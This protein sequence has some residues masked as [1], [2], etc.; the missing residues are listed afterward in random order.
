M[1]SKRVLNIVT[2]LVL[3]VSVLPVA[4]TADPPEPATEP[5][6]STGA[7]PAAPAKPA[8]PEDSGVESLSGSFVAFDPSVG[9]DMC[10]VPG[11]T[12]TFCF[13][14]HSYTTDWEYVYNLWT[15][16]PTDWT[17][18]DVYVQGT[19]VCSSGAS[20]GAFSWSFQT[21]P[22]EVNIAHSRNQATTDDCVAYYCFEV[23]SGAGGGD[24]LESWYWDGDGYGSPPHWPCSDDQ[25]TPAGQSA[26]DEYVNPQAA[27][28]ECLPGLFLSPDEINVEGC[29]ALP[30]THIFNLLNFTGAEGTFDLTYDVL[31]G[32]ATL[33]GPDQIYLGNGVN[34]DFE[35]ELTPDAC[36]PEGAQVI[37]TIEADGNG[38][39]DLSTITKTILGEIV[40]WESV[41]NSAPAWAG[42]GYPV[43]GCTAMN[44]AGEWVTY[45]IGDQSGY[46]GFWGYNHNTNTWYQPAG[47]APADR[48]AP[49]WAY[50]DAT[51][52]CYMTGGATAAGGGNLAE[53]WQYD[54]V[55]DA[56]TQLPNFTSIRDFHD[57]WV[58]TLNG[59]KFLCIGGGVN[60]S[61]VLVQST[62]CYDIAGGAWNAEN[63]DMDPYPTDPFGA[64]DGTLHADTGDQFWYVGGA[65][66]NFATVTDAAWYWDDADDAWHQAGN[67]GFPRYRVEGDF[68]HG[69]FYQLAGS[70]GGFTPT[71]TSVRGVNEGGTWNWYQ[72]DD[73]PVSRMDNVA[74]MLPPYTLAGQGPVPASERNLEFV[75]PGPLPVGAIELGLDWVSGQPAAE[76][77]VVPV[78]ANPEAVLWDQYANWSSTDHAAQDFETAYDIY[79]IFA[80]DDFENLETWNIDTI[81]TR[82]G[83]G[84][85]VDLNNATAINWWICPDNGGEPLCDPPG[86]GNE[87]WTISL[88]PTDPQVALGVSEPEDVVLTLDTPIVL[89]AGTWWLVYQVALEN[90]LYGQYGWSSTTDAVWGHV[91]MQN[92]P[93]GGFGMGTGWWDNTYAYDFMFRLEGAIGGPP[94]ETMWSVDGYGDSAADYV[95]WLVQCP[96]CT[97]IGWLDGY[98][99]DSETGDVDPTC[100]DAVV[101]IEPGNLDF[102]VDPLTGY[103]GPVELISGT[104]TVDATAPGY[105]LET[106]VVD[107]IDQMTTTVDFNLWRP[108]ISVEPTDFVSVPVLIDVPT[109]FPMVI[110]NVGHLPLDFEISEIPGGMVTLDRAGPDMRTTWLEGDVEIGPQVLAEL[111]AGGAT[112]FFV[113]MRLQA[114]LSEASAIEDWNAR[115]QYVYDSLVAVTHAQNAVISYAQ[116]HGLEYETRLVINAVFIKGGTLDDV[117]ALAALADV[118]QISANKIREL[119]DARAEGIDA[120]G[121]NMDN[122][123]PDAGDYGMEASEVW[124]EYGVFGDGIVVANIDTGAFYQ[125]EALDRNYRGNTSGAI[126]GPY[127]H[128]FNWYDPSAVCPNPLEPCDNH[129]HGSGTMGIMAGETADL[130]EQIGAAPGAQWIACK[131]CESSSCSDAAL[132]GCADWMVAPCPAGVAPGDPSCDPAMRPHVINNSWGGGGCDNWYDSYVAA[133]VAGG[134]FPAFSAGNTTAC[135]AVGS[136]GDTPQAFGTAA[137]G[138]DGVN[139]Y[140]GGPSCYFPNPSC[141]PSAHEVDPHL[142]APT[143][144][145]TSG[146]AAGSYYNLSGT[147]GASPHTAGCVALIWSANPGW[148]GNIGDTFTL[149]EQTAD[150]TSTQ[151]WNE[152]SCGKPACAGSDPYPNYEY[153]W[154]YLDCFAAVDAVYQ[155]D[156]PWLLTDPVSGTVPPEDF[157]VIDVTVECTQT[158]DYTGTLRIQNSDPCYNPFDVP[159]GFHCVE[160]IEMTGM[161][162]TLMT[163]DPVVG[164]PVEFEV[165]MSPDNMNM[166]YNY[167]IDMDDGT[168]YSGDSSDDP[169][170]FSHIYTEPGPYTVEFRAWNCDMTEPMTDSL[171]IT[172]SEGI[173]RY[174]LPIVVKDY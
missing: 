4:V 68:K 58:G 60:A 88:P 46:T 86:D 125:H 30:Q 110:S 109:T 161:E 36:L 81:T 55:A 84:S 137:H 9:G 103:F 146:N 139:L 148:I 2:L 117:N 96:P 113:R 131:G 12:Q 101:H 8:I 49:D 156:L 28:P 39:T 89:P 133:W 154:G 100:T 170:G 21:A 105:S 90:G 127:D 95:A 31:S 26:C 54:P 42:A 18:L 62:Q 142:N 158:M 35:V 118:K 141:D 69:N 99:M 67:T 165:D 11:A 144:G 163:P 80:A 155:P 32:N 162:M 71:T 27:I 33:T 123:D 29:A 172:V 82:G 98:V 153:G 48:W 114:D 7:A 57:S 167:E 52:L 147:S 15:M 145:R 24:A 75:A 140:A 91:G 10:F 20:W 174:Y 56:W 50:D 87:I 149:L 169:H 150:R 126:G 43:D 64:A 92:N 130:V 40:G 173:S 121:W 19:P 65:V 171:E 106:E 164:V 97:E 38:Y 134:Q 111:D 72:L 1:S 128:D 119:E 85:P 77:V 37:A 6:N 44:G 112:D 120:W 122:L 45:L 70:S 41:P 124:N 160:C 79:D 47:A 107:V 76:P 93:G 14:A 66:D 61:S 152:G 159:L 94:P 5:L 135:G 34:Q 115:G 83:W 3:L 78:A 116:A 108:V 16:F 102:L 13:E 63:A 136:P 74:V 17:V 166:P 151:A 157:V 138:S 25:Y 143:F 168:V 104:Y 22:Y 23:V 129:G 73:L 132:T 59:T 51:N 53:A